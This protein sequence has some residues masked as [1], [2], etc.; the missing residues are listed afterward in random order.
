M[1]SVQSALRAMG[2]AV[3]DIVCSALGAAPGLVLAQ[4]AFMAV[5]SAHEYACQTSSL[6]CDGY[7]PFSLAGRLLGV[8]VGSICGLAMSHALVK[9]RH[10]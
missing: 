9:G 2:G 5:P 1:V 6:L 8:I 3:L 4:L 10:K 7:I